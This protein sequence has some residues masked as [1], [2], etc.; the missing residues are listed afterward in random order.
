MFNCFKHRGS[1]EIIIG[2]MFCGKTSLGNQ[3]ATVFADIGF[4]VLRI[5]SFLDQR[6]DIEGIKQNQTVSTHNSSFTKLSDKIFQTFAKNLSEIDANPFQVIF[7]DESQFFEDLYDNVFRWV[8]TEGKHIIVSGLCGDFEKKKFGQT[9]DLIPICDTVNKLQA[10]CYY[11]L[12]DLEKCDFKGN[13]LAISAPFTARKKNEDSLKC[14]KF[15]QIC[16]G[17]SDIYVPVCRYHH[18]SNN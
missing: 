11:C 17:G 14:D 2:P 7:I 12:E 4:K 10:R 18:N 3:K 1:L 13:I 9:L 15:S 6:S 16:V 5:S 8:E